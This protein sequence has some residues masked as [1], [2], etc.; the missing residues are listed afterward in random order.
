MSA[1]TMR[2]DDPSAS[3]ACSYTVSSARQADGSCRR[4]GGADVGP[5]EVLELRDE[6]QNCSCINRLGEVM[7]HPRFL[8]LAPIFVLPPS[9][10]RDQR[11]ARQPRVGTYAPRQLV[12]AHAWQADV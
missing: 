12:T 11:H 9:R 10:H 3:R 6:R 1:L 7:I 4:V 2:R 5:L 8:R